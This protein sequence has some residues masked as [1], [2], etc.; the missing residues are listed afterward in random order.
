MTELWFEAAG[1]GPPLVLVH[2]GI[3]DARMWDDLV[4]PLAREHRVVR[5]DM[6][7]Y[8]RSG[9]VTSAYSPS[10][11]LVSVLD[12]LGIERAA[13]CG[14][15]FGGAVALEAAAAHPERVAAL[16]AVCCAVDW[17]NVPDDLVARIEEADAAGEA[18]DLDRAVEL[19]LRIWVDGEGRAE[20]VDADVRERV[21]V[22][23]RRALELAAQSAADAMWLDPPV[24]ER[25][26]EIA[27]PT[28]VVAGEH[29]VAFMIESCR[30]IA[31]AVPGARLAVMDGV[32]HLPPLERPAEF[33]ALLRE[34]V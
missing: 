14:V 5:Y 29:D 25:L 4:G 23:N 24:A 33:L 15:S 20:P 18:G 34:A 22:M 16:V 2:A 32:A 7:G 30:R 11:D 21:R 26:G 9:A 17:S 6:R 12:A 28:L 13:V 1:D 8:G 31:A 3:C 27:C 10:G 19:E